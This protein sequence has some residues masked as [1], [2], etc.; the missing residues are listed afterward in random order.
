MRACEDNLN[1]SIFT[2][3]SPPCQGWAGVFE[4]LSVLLGK[5]CHPRHTYPTGKYILNTLPMETV[6]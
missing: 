2:P 5:P 4:L 3:D 1:G 6:D